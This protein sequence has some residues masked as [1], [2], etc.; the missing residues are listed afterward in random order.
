MK[1][2][3]ISGER[4]IESFQNQKKSQKKRQKIY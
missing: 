1:N 3:I 2:G 4:I